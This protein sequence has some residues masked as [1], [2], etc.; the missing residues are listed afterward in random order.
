MRLITTAETAKLCRVSQRTIKELVSLNI[1]IA[2]RIG[3]RVFIDQDRLEAQ[4]VRYYRCNAC[5]LTF[6]VR[7]GTIFEHSHIALNVW[8]YA[9]HYLATQPIPRT[10]AFI[11]FELRISER[12]AWYLLHRLLGRCGSVE[13]FD[14]TDK[15]SPVCY[16]AEF[17]KI[18]EELEVVAAREH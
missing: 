15:D 1:I 11:A 17:A 12:S 10:A 2:I 8:L 16:I 6:S 9:M 3:R 18:D 4:I 14:F 5:R 7:T 13:E